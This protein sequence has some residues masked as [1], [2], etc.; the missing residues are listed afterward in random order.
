MRDRGTGPGKHPSGSISFTESLTKKYILLFYNNRY[1]LRDSRRARSWRSCTSTARGRGGG[2]SVDFT[3]E[4]SGYRFHEVKRKTKEE[5]V[6]TSKAEESAVDVNIRAVHPRA[7]STRTP[8]CRGLALIEPCCVD[9]FIHS[10]S[11]IVGPSQSSYC[12][13]A[14]TPSPPALVVDPEVLA[15]DVPVRSSST[16]LSL[17]IPQH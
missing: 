8:S 2:G 3:S 11:T 16:Y 17:L 13:G 5:A 15:L 4:E 12:T 6:A 1:Q 14:S 9:M 10:P 7:E